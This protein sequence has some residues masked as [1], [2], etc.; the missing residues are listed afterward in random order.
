[1]QNDIK[2]ILDKAFGPG[3]I[4]R[5]QINY[6][7]R[8]PTCKDS[9]KSKK[10]LVIRLDDLRYH[11]WV[12][13]VK[14]KDVRFLIKKFRPGLI[15][16]SD[17]FKIQKNI[18]IEEEEL[19]LELP[20]G[21]VLLSDT[22]IKDPDLIATKKYLF[23]RGLLEK[24]LL[25]WRILGTPIGSFRR[26]A[27]IPSFDALG[28]LNYFVARSIDESG[29]YR[30]KNSNVSKRS[31]IFNEIDIIWNEPIILVEG[32]FDAINC[33]ENTIPIL[34]S[35][36]SKGSHLFRQILLHQTQ[37][38]VALDSDLKQKAYKLATLLRT[39]G[40]DVR[41]VFP[42]DGKDLGDMS[43]NEVQ[44]ILSQSKPYTDIMRLTH[45]ISKMKSGSIL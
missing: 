42:P 3:I 4:S 20:K 7:T 31:V 35:S 39:T 25:R 22:R 32:V 17:K 44:N 38:L 45:K 16:I 19:E 14:G 29:S 21:A 34:G 9:R 40:C 41:I 10:K 30:Y 36:L 8:C 15:E 2:R 26:K 18:D 33:P 6:S 13:G 1:V 28:H 11:C 5:D 27:I 12:C 24:D 43:K 37:C 23:K